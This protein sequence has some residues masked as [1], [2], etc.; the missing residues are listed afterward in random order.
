MKKSNGFN[1]LPSHTTSKEAPINAVL[2]LLKEKNPER[3]EILKKNVRKYYDENVFPYM[4]EAVMEERQKEVRSIVNVFRV[5]EE[6]LEEKRTAAKRDRNRR[7][8]KKRRDKEGK[9]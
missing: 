7:K 6:K 5:Y 1:P 8:N 9:R 3:L 2:Q 4:L